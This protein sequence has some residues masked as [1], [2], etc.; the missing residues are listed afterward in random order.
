VRVMEIE[1]FGKSSAIKYEKA[2]ACCVCVCVLIH[3][4]V[5]SCQVIYYNRMSNKGERGEAERMTHNARREVDL[6]DINP[7]IL[8]TI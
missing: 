5:Y 2:H 7:H 8:F 4:V 3:A 1:K 6:S